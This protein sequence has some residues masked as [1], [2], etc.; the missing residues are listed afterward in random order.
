MCI[1]LNN[2]SLSLQIIQLFRTTMTSI[3]YIHDQNHWNL[4]NRGIIIVQYLLLCYMKEHQNE[5]FIKKRSFGR[6]SCH[7]P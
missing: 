7:T 1:T 3:N 4:I 2:Y 5:K 6:K